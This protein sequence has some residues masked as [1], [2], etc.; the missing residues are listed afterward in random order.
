MLTLDVH[1]EAIFC[2]YRSNDADPCNG[3]CMG[4]VFPGGTFKD[5]SFERLTALGTGT[6]DVAVDIR[7][8]SVDSEV[9]PEFETDHDR[10]WAMFVYERGAFNR[11]ERDRLL[12]KVT[13][14]E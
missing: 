6:H 2:H 3:G 10:A 1:D 7:V 8:E 12:K 4:R 11:M 13:Q 9:R 5:W 14:T